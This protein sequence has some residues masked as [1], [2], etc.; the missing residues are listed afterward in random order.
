MDC[1]ENFDEENMT[2]L[3]NIQINMLND[4]FILYDKMIY[5]NNNNKGNKFI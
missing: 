5:E 2:N 3:I 4:K 1:D